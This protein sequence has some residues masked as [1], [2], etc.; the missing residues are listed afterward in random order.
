MKAVRSTY[1]LNRFIGLPRGYLLTGQ[2]YMGSGKPG[3]L[4]HSLP[5]M[6]K[7]FLTT[8]SFQS[9]LSSQHVSC[10]RPYFQIIIRRDPRC[11]VC[12][13]LGFRKLILTPQRSE[14]RRVGKGGTCEWERAA[15]RA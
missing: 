15:R 9:S 13:L 4:V 7:A 5:S 8:I 14:E 1:R 10:G 3:G 2:L 12:Q 11:P 6:A